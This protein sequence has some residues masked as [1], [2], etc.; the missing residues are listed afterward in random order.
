VIPD[1]AEAETLFTL[2]HSRGVRDP[3]WKAFFVES[4][5]EFLVWQSHPYGRLSE[6]DLNWLMGLVAD[7]PSPSTPALLFALVRELN[8]VPER[9]V[10][11]AL[12]HSDNRFPVR[13]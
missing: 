3:E 2:D 11:L 1:R 5:V 10:A 12:M 13:I 9:L 7:S 8:D 4:L 6:S